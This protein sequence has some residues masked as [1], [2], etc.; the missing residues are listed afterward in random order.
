[1]RADEEDIY[2]ELVLDHC[3]DP[4]HKGK[5]TGCTHG[6]R[7]NN[8]LCGDVCRIELKLSSGGTI[9]DAWF[10]ADGCRISR[11]AA[12]VLLEHFVG[13]SIEDV[14]NFS[15]GDML[16]LFNVR[17]TPN[18]QKCWLLPWRVLQQAIYAPL[19]ADG[20]VQDDITQFGE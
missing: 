2:Q 3:E 17:L 1:M 8:P 20:S 13:K 5:C 7:G 14:R 15:A 18:R 9:E 19:A 11:A 16:G 4:F 10:D 12:S 6:H